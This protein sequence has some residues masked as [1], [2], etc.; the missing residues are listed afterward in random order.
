MNSELLENEY[1]EALGYMAPY[2]KSWQMGE[3]A[4]VEE[5]LSNAITEIAESNRNINT[6]MKNTQTEINEKLAVSNK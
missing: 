5:K 3:Q 4:F 6:V 1:T 2:M